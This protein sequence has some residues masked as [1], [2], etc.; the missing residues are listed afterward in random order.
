M[1]RAD[2][3]SRLIENA[4]VRWSKGK[5]KTRDFRLTHPLLIMPRFVL[6][7]QTDKSIQPNPFC[8]SINFSDRINCQLKYQTI[9]GKINLQGAKSLTYSTKKHP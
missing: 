8:V 6:L 5:E 7:R 3:D 2:Q 4:L 9:E 1:S